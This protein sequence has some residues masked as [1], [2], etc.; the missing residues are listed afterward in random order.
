MAFDDG[1]K[2]VTAGSVADRL[3]ELA[4]EHSVPGAQLAVHGPRGGLSVAVGVVRAGAP[5]PVTPET[6]FPYGSVTKAF[7]AAVV[8]RL[9]ADG[10]LAFDDPAVDYLA[11][12]E[13]AED[14]RMASVTL[15]NLL[16][17]TSGLIAD[18]E[19]DDSANVDPARYA[20]SAARTGIL[21][22]PGSAFS[23]SNTGYVVLGRVVEA[24]TDMTWRQAVER[25]VLN[26]LG[27]RPCF[28]DGGGAGG[29]ALADCHAVRP[30]TGRA[31]PVGLYLPRS[32]AP[33]AGLAGSA[34]DLVA[35]A[36]SLLGA[37]P[38]PA[39]LDPEVREA[40]RERVPGADPFGMADGWGLGLGH[41]GSPAGDW[42]GHDGT[43]DG[44]TAHLR[45]HPGNGTVVAL[46][47]NATAGTRMWADV[48]DALREAGVP[49]GDSRP[50]VPPPTG[51]EAVPDVFGDY[52]NGDTAFT[53]RRAADRPA[54]GLEFTDGS[55]LRADLTVHD[56]LVFTA[57]RTDAD[58]APYLGR[59][60]TD[61]ASGRVTAMQLAG[62]AATRVPA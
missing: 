2:D 3:R 31:D 54:A 49:V 60:V 16:S 32:W 62:R 15:R 1:G 24:V 48:V 21:H 34:D 37:G 8:A 19:P 18:H 29:R 51:A 26:P 57:R 46:T 11:E 4:R 58:E 47:T 41:Y 38:R 9:V 61:P 14:E 22:E 6:A 55:G 33:A 30:D 10:D 39:L 56:G 17:H 36:R 7:T 40:L 23:Y 50:E 28:V 5:A 25:L 43:V 44:G 53:V 12:F 13:G 35:F 52:R 20:A 59:F 42:L 45:F 27:I